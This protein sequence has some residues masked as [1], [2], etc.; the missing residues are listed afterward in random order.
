MH[1]EKYLKIKNKIQFY[2]P[3]ELV[4]EKHHLKN[5]DFT[6]NIFQYFRNLFFFEYIFCNKNK[7]LD[8]YIFFVINYTH[9]SVMY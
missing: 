9:Y 1:C 4:C 3:S 6:R 8:Y 2:T 7:I 5:I